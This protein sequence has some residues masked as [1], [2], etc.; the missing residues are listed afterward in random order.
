MPYVFF[1]QSF[2]VPFNRIGWVWLGFISAAVFDNE[3]Q[4]C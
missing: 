1:L 4:H 2:V 3:K